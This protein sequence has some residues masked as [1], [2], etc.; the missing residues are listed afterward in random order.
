MKSTLETAVNAYLTMHTGTGT[1]KNWQSEGN[2]EQDENVIFN[3]LQ[4]VEKI[5]PNKGLM[6]VSAFSYH[7]KIFQS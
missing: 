4:F 3:Q 6:L 7:A 1:S 2:T 5:F